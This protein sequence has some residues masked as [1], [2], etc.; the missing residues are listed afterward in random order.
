MSQTEVGE[1]NESGDYTRGGSS[2]MPQKNNPIISHSIVAATQANAGLL[3]S[4]HQAL[5]QE[6]ERAAHSWQLEWLTLPQMVTLTLAAL[7]KAIFLSENLV[8]DVERM[9]ANV[10]A[11]HGVMLAEAVRLALV[12]HVGNEEAKRLVTEAARVASE[13]GRHLIEVVREFVSVKLD[14]D[15]LRDE[16][17]YLGI[18]D[19]LISRVLAEAGPWRNPE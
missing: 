17:N 12:P 15:A 9:K 6:H 4:M 7:N 11:S 1:L 5:L 10:K 19:E 18:S 13:Q 14:W 3:A 2:T 8:V 16:S